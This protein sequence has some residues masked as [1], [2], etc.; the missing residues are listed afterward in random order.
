M[1]V[2]VFNPTDTPVRTEWGT[3]DSMSWKCLPD[4]GDIQHLIDSN[5]LVV[6]DVP[7]SLAG[8]NPDAY[9]AF[10]ELRNS[11]KKNRRASAVNAP[12]RDTE[13]SEQNTNTETEA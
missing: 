3:V 2:V 13:V 1:A 4:Q 9:E 11:G 12:V 10:E 6:P 5:K 7:G 8:I